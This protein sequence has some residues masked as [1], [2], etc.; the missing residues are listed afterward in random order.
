MT[1][2]TIIKIVLSAPPTCQ[3]RPLESLK[4]V[5]VLLRLAVPTVGTPV[6]LTAVGQRE[7]VHIPA[8]LLKTVT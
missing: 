8:V 7:R 5:L 1:A 4:Q 3:A 2:I 6:Q